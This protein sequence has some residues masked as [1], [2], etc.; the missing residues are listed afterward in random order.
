MSS[1][2]NKY[3]T[4]WNLFYRKTTHFTKI[5]LRTI[6]IQNDNKIYFFGCQ[7]WHCALKKNIANCQEIATIANKLTLN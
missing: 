5:S 1:H 2:L 4:N 7:T 6:N 3:N